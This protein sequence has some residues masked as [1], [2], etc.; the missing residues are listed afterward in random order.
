LNSFSSLKQNI[1][2][3]ENLDFSNDKICLLSL[4]DLII[5]TTLFNKSKSSFLRTFLEIL[6]LLIILYE[7]KGKNILQNPE[8][9][10]SFFRL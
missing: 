4:F 10:I 2:I 8:Y 3:S 1:E 9:S 5:N 7:F 6:F